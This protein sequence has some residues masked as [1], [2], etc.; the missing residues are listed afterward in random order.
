MRA[1]QPPQRRKGERELGGFGKAENTVLEEDTMPEFLKPYIARLQE[2]WGKL[3]L[4]RRVILGSVLAV[5]IGALVLVGTISS[6][7]GKV[8]LYQGLEPKDFAAVTSKL[9]ELNFSFST[10]G[11]STIFVPAEKKDAAIMALAQ[12]NLI[13]QGVA[14]WELFDI[15]K[16]SETQ[17]EKDIK[18]QR[19]IMGALSR[20]LATLKSV[21]S[22]Q[23]NIAFPSEELFTEKAEAVT[24][25][26]LL[27]YAPGYDKLTRKEIEGIV[28]LVARS[29]P[30]LKKE[31]VSVAG[32]DGEILNDFD[33]EI[34][35]ARWELKEVDEKLKIQE[36]ERIK[37][38][39]D[40]K[41]SLSYTY[42]E[43]IY[44][45]RFDVVR[46]DLRLRWDKEE[47]EKHEV[48]PVVMVPDDPRTPY[49]ERVVKDSL[50]V[51]S[52]TTTEEFEGNGFTPEGPAGT[53]PNIPPGYK[54]KDYQKARYTKKEDI[55]NN[56]FNKTHRLI[57]KQPWELERVALSVMLDGRWERVGERADD[58]GYERKYI[59]VSDEELQKVTDLLKK[60]IGFDV[61]RGDMISVKHVQ[62][63]RSKQFEAE[64]AELRHQKQ[65]RRLLLATLIT[66]LVL[67][68]ATVLYQAIKKE[69]ERRRR[70]RE[71]ELAAQ[72]QMMREA[73]LRA[74][75]E[76]GVEVELSLEERARRE[77]LEN[78]INLAKER[79][80]DVAHLLRTWLAEE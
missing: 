53:E 13:P 49:S 35:K 41:K 36:R 62:K 4:V 52:K 78:A 1:E 34:D 20:T 63:D 71:E 65:M 38:L 66:L 75:E 79:P 29:V 17:A 31:N 42:G 70:L 25:A 37:L 45:D 8:V 12:E 15:D 26:V 47:I 44:G 30:G 18:K 27:Q 9:Q 43:G 67:A 55:K 48:E 28:T 76:E 58:Q 10:S 2:V 7:Q 61:A 33:N 51:S 5:I 3:D 24:A 39:A 59:P 56:E 22:A 68:L 69:M 32:P 46:L 50:E 16:W 54:D 19:A 21:E 40:I 74:I 6:D 23:V 72:Q 11:T 64:D 80:E 14:G 77:M 60:A 57:S 73:A